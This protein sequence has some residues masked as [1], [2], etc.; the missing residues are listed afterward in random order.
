MDVRL[1]RPIGHAGEPH[2]GVILGVFVHVQP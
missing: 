1:K 2:Q